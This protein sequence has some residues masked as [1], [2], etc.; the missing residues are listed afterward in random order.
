MAFLNGTG[1]ETLLCLFHDAGIDD[2]SNRTGGGRTLDS[3]ISSPSAS[4]NPH[5]ARDSIVG[6]ALDWLTNA[7]YF[8]VDG[9]RPRLEVIDLKYRNYPPPSFASASASSLPFYPSPIPQ[10]LLSQRSRPRKTSTRRG[11]WHSNR[12]VRR[13]IVP[14][15]LLHPPKGVDSAADD[16][17]FYSYD[18]NPITDR[19]ANNVDNY[20]LVL[21]HNL[22]S[23]RDIVVHPKKRCVA[24]LYL[25]C[26]V[27]FA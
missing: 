18:F 14:P 20:R 8:C 22:S 25:L 11:N 3:G 19:L 6:L 24:Y 4:G 5:Q 9:E 2:S 7:L 10:Q 12:R 15:W 13:T 1:K 21:L 17:D 23:P 27:F 26:R 16:Y